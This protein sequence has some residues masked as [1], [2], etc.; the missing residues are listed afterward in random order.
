MSHVHPTDPSKYV[1]RAG[2]AGEYYCTYAA[3]DEVYFAHRSTQP[4][5]FID[6]PPGSSSWYMRMQLRTSFFSLGPTVHMRDG[7]PAYTGVND[8]FK[9][10]IA[11]GVCYA[12]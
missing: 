8:P 2:A 3:F 4:A 7:L 1:C 11:R 6:A 12:A 5:T 10:P 9:S